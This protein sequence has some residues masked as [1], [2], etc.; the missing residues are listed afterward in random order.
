MNWRVCVLD[1]FSSGKMENLPDHPDLN[2]V[3]AD[4]T[5]TA[6]VDRILKGA[7]TVF[8]L[9]AIS[10]VGRSIENPIETHLVNCVGTLN[11]LEAA[12]RHGIR[13]FIFA[14]SA[15]VYGAL[16]D[17]PKEEAGPTNPLSP[18]AI[19]KLASEGACRIYAELHGVETV[20]LRFFN[21]YGPRQDPS[22]PYSGVI[23]VFLRH[24]KGAS[25]PTIFGDGEQTRD[26]VYVSDVVAALIAAATRSV[27]GGSVFNVGT[28]VATS[29]NELW[30]CVCK[31]GNTDIL[32]CYARARAGDVRDSV[33]SI[34]SG[35]E[36]LGWGPEVELSEGIRRM[37]LQNDN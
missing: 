15:A 33:A 23:S 28:G 11:L 29:I 32:P 3:R 14:S 26:F 25:R 10:S 6:E 4:V 2:V 13:R 7:R 35:R 34:A 37:V 9:A 24:L 1:D 30:R 31:A 22:S 19:D 27:R 8:H 17:L 20:C 36:T 5:N 12:R 18:Y 16:V 21:V